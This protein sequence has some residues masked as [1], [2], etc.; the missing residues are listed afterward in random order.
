MH[1]MADPAKRWNVRNVAFGLIAFLIVNALAFAQQKPSPEELLQAVHKKSD[2][3]VLGAYVLTGTIVVNSGTKDEKTGS[4]AVYRDH[5]RVRVD[6]KMGEQVETRLTVGNKDYQDPNKLMFGGTWLT[7]FDRIWDPDNRN[8]NIFGGKSGWSNMSRRKVEGVEA[9]CMERKHE[10]G[11][12]H[13]CV[14]A[15]RSVLLDFNSNE[16]SDYSTV[17]EAA[18]PQTVKVSERTGAPIEVRKIQVAAYPVESDLFS[19]PA[20]AWE[21]ETCDSLKLPQVQE[22]PTP[23]RADMARHDTLS[24]IPAY[25]FVDKQGKVGAVKLAAVLPHNL[26]PKVMAALGQWHFSPATC[27]GKPVNIG[28]LIYIPGKMF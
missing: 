19:I 22:T 8:A 27:N 23:I 18:F 6:V 4:L 26:Q 13:L 11:K 17:G 20:G 10:Y 7:E 5:D 12:D 2:L 1:G 25:V 24:S 21:F 16:F 15:A 14:D 9:W 28:I 3:T